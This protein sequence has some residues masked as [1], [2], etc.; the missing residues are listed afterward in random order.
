[1]SCSTSCRESALVL[2]IWRGTETDVKL[3]D[4]GDGAAARVLGP[5]TKEPAT[6]KETKGTERSMDDE[7]RKVMHTG[8]DTPAD[9]WWS[10]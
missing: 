4:C 3:I 10:E 8:V 5:R 7:R 6:R 1:M 9:L 2:P